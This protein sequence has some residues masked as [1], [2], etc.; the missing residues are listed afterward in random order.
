MTLGGGDK[1]GD[2]GRTAKPRRC[3]LSGFCSQSTRD[4]ENNQIWQE[5]LVVSKSTL[6]SLQTTKKAKTNCVIETTVDSAPTEFE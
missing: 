4:F 3:G 6:V 5:Q 2:T 1:G